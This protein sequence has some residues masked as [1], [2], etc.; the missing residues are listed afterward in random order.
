MPR[1]L[2]RQRQAAE[3]K[4][5]ARQARRNQQSTS[6]VD[7]AFDGFEDSIGLFGDSKVA[8]GQAG[9]LIEYDGLKLHLANVDGGSVGL[10]AH[11][12]WNSAFVLA[13]YIQRDEGS[14]VRGKRVLEFGAAAGLDGL[15]AVKK[16]AA[17]VT[18]SD[19]PDPKVISNL[20][21]NWCEN[22]LGPFLQ[23]SLGQP[24]QQ[25]EPVLEEGFLE[26]MDY[27]RRIR[28]EQ[29]CR[30]AVRGH[31]WG[32]SVTPLLDC[33]AADRTAD[34]DVE[35][36]QS[37]T[38][39][40]DRNR[41]DLIMMADTLWVADGHRLL[42]ES[43]KACLAPKSG[44]KIIVCCGLHTGLRVV[45]Q[46]LDMARSS[47]FGYTVEL[48]E[49]RQQPRWGETRTEEEQRADAAKLTEVELLS[50]DVEERNRT[51]LVYEL[52]FTDK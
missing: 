26:M 41:Y 11:F 24:Q 38:A 2:E 25:Q 51:V 5:L 50:F 8:H 30:S 6:D 19:Y 18:L 34:G 9:K 1:D 21:R 10:M 27:Q 35:G 47:P 32:E 45:Q 4:R 29:G 36:G 13:E 20:E 16:G 17:F 3:A 31:A 15:L 40:E 42:L 23:A 46:F 52:L 33:I 28:S 39:S 7:D 44:S 14:L 43:C 49:I 12:V 22:I 37:T 48:K